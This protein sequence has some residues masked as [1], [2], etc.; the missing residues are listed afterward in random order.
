[1][2][3]PKQVGY[4][5]LEWTCP[6]CGTRSGGR[7]MV[8]PTCGAPQPA[9]ARFEVPEQG[10]VIAA[11][12]PSAA[13]VAQT[14]AAGPDV[15]C[16]FCGARNSA[17]ATE[18]HQCHAPLAGATARAQGEKLGA[19]PSAS[20]VEITCHVCGATNPGAA[21]MCAKCGAPLQRRAAATKA[22]APAPLPAPHHGGVALWWLWGIGAVVLVAIAVFAWLAFRSDSYTA[23]AEAA[24]WERSVE[25]L[26]YAPVEKQAWQDEV[27]DGAEVLQCR[28]ELLRTSDEPVD[29]A[30]E[31]CGTPYTVDTGTGYGNV[32][33]DCE[34]QLFA[35][36]CTY[37][38]MEW[39]QVDTVVASGEGFSPA[40]P[41]PALA[42]DRKLGERA[43]RYMCDVRVDDKLYSFAL[44]AEAYPLCRPQS[45]W[46]VQV[47]GLG[48]VI[49]ATP[50][51]AR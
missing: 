49:E 2:A 6:T 11:A 24:R 19:A 34:Y 45:R 21:H 41:E 14:V 48:S 17:T 51:S 4:V 5:E 10:V 23:V 1:M 36:K 37:Q 43:E 33:Q 9:E 32:L 27:P 28:D 38:T 50:E 46:R 30:R 8:C 7:V 3:K 29:G 31:V 40:W 25:L 13:Q 35:P 12:D 39:L 20:P 22:G 18:C 26:G 16:P 42:P 47:N 15:Q 44:T